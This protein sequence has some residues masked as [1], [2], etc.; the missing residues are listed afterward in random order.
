MKALDLDK[1]I[2][3]VDSLINKKKEEKRKRLLDSAYACFTQNTISG[4]TIAEICMRANLAKGT[5]YLYF[6][7]KEDI[8]RALNKRISYQVLQ[9]TYH[10]KMKK[11]LGFIDHAVSM[12]GALIQYFEKDKEV[13]LLMKKDFVWPISEEE[14]ITS[15]DPVMI[16]IRKD[17]QAYA[18]ESGWSNHQ[19]LVRLYAL[20]C[21]IS[22][23]CYS[24]IIDHFPT[25]LDEVK[26]EIDQMIR[27]ALLPKKA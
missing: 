21:M 3:E 10:Q 14:F 8:V 5:F 22:S 13:V 20:I 2:V 18:Q 4:T 26:P 9:D 27:S 24:S 15:N 23:I 19:L 25:N 12:A 7:D 6:K 1:K 11:D 16:E 17:I